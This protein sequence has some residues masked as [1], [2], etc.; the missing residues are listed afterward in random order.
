MKTIPHERNGLGI[1]SIFALLIACGGCSHTRTGLSM[2]DERTAFIRNGVTTREE[3][4]ETLGLPLHDLK[5]ER[6]FAYYWE[7]EGPRMSYS[8]LGKPNEID[9]KFHRWLF[10]VRLDDSNRVNRHGKTRQLETET[11]TEA[12]LRWLEKPTD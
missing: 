4:V 2:T 8:V 7:I 6:T 3:I 10:I 12:I 1:I 5:S 11:A 9:G